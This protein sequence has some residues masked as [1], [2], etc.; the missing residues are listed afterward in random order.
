[1]SD[2]DIE[3]LREAGLPLC[4]PCARR[5]LNNPYNAL[6]PMRRSEGES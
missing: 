5:R 3:R 4:K 6:L 2:I 1:M